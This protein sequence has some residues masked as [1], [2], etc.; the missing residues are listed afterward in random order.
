MYTVFGILALCVIAIVIVIKL[1]RS[2]KF[3]KFCKDISE[4]KLEEDVVPKATIKE[5]T[6]AEIDLN[7]KV[8]ENQREAEKLTAEGGSINQFLEKRGVIKDKKE[9]TK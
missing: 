9:N 7:K 4:G 6:Q 1:M 2:K 3:D 5:I 8:K